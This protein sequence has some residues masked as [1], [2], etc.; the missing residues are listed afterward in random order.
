V[1]GRPT[2]AEYCEFP[3][4]HAF[5]QS[6]ETEVASLKPPRSTFPKNASTITPGGTFAISDEAIDMGSMDCGRLPGKLDMLIK[7]G[8]PGKETFELRLMGDLDIAMERYGLVTQVGAS[9]RG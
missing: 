8:I 7:Y 6:A 4:S 9:W 5:L 3:R 2:V 1:T